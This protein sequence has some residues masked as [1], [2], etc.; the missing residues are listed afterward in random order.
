MS[1]A[2]PCRVP[3]VLTR[4]SKVGACR[5]VNLA[6]RLSFRH[7]DSQLPFLIVLA[8]NPI[9][10]SR[11]WQ[12]SVY[13]IPYS[14][15]LTNAQSKSRK[16]GTHASKPV[17]VQDLSDAVWIVT[18]FLKKGLKFVEVPDGIYLLRNGFDA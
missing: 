12:G 16:R 4:R 5:W 9:R 10:V 7:L 1:P 18:A 6:R 3:M 14:K 17:L 13:I 11:T 2:P 8:Q 15:K